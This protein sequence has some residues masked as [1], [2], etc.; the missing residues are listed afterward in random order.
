[1][2]AYQH[3][4]VT[5]PDETIQQSLQQKKVDWVLVTSPAIARS[6]HRMFPESLQHAKLASLSP[7]VTATLT[8]LGLSAAV[9][10]K[11]PTLN[12]LIESIVHAEQ[13][14]RE[15]SSI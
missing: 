13:E 11:Q 15:H 3:G 9:T 7:A 12:S 6:L 2:V 10:A 5:E 8:E 1:M 14:T 4:D